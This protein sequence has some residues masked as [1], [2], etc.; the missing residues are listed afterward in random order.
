MRVADCFRPVSDLSGEHCKPLRQ[1]G[2]LELPGKGINIKH[3]FS[4]RQTKKYKIVYAN[5][6]DTFG[7]KKKGGTKRQHLMP[8]PVFP[9]RKEMNIKSREH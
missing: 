4:E 3:G 5:N 8:S 1:K 2:I 9:T 7:D 6:S